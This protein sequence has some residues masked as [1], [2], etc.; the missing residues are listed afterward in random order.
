MTLAAELRTSTAKAHQRAE[1]SPFIGRFVR[2]EITPDEY[3]RFLQCLW[4]L[5]SNL[6]RALDRH[7]GAPFIAPLWWPQLRR[8][9]AIEADLRALGARATVPASAPGTQRYVARLM[10]LD[11]H[12]PELLVAHAYVRYLG[13][14]AGGQSLARHAV[15]VLG[16]DDATAF[17]RFDLGPPGGAR[18]RFRAQLDALPVTADVQRAIVDEASVAFDLNLGLFSDLG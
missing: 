2:H 11:E 14:L 9:P 8:T 17:Y 15:A 16:R 6:E 10:D 1:S 18:Q 13:D 12:A 5:Y 7:A 4:A 3:A